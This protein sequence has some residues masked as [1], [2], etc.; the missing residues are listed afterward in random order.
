MKAKIISIIPARGGSKGIPQKNIRLLA[1]RPLIAYT[2]DC[3]LN[4]K[5]INRV[6]VSTDDEGIATISEKYGVEVVKR[7]ES[8]AQDN[9]PTIDAVL[10]VLEFLE[11]QN[12][13]HIIIVLLQPT[14]PLRNSQDIDNAIELFFKNTCDSVISVCESEHPP[15]W[16]Y[17]ID[18]QYLKPILGDNYSK[19]RR[20]DLPKSYILNGAIYI[21]TVEIIQECRSFNSHKVSP[22]IMPSIRSVDIDDEL[23]FIVA[24]YIFKMSKNLL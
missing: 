10:H 15:F 9:S 19:M 2:I 14:S 20:Q 18:D 13:K 3:A 6:V 22:Y 8:L 16:T 1:G 12:E 24:E 5:Y 17:K 11:I 4:S 23:D 7:P 21:S